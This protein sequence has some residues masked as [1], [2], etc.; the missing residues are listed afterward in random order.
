MRLFVVKVRILMAV[1][2]WLCAFP[3][4]TLLGGPLID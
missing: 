4:M 1:F 3:R 2:S